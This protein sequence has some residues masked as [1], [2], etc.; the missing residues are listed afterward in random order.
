VIAGELLKGVAMTN[1]RLATAVWLCVLLSAR[2]PAAAQSGPD[3]DPDGAPGYVQ[4]VFD[5]GQIDS[6]N[7]YNGQL[8]VPIPLGPSYPIGPRLKLQLALSYNSQ[9]D[10]YGKPLAQSPDFSYRPLSGN[11]SLGIGWSLTL[12]AIKNCQHG[13]FTFGACYY[14]PDGS[15]HMFNKPRANGSIT[16]DASA[17]FLRGTGPYDM[18]DGDG[19]H[20]EFGAEG[21][22]TGYDAAAT[23]FAKGRDGWYLTR[24][25]D[26]F[27]N[28]YAV[29]YWSNINPLWTYSLP[30]QAPC[31]PGVAPLLQ[32]PATHVT[33]TS[34]IPRDIT[35]PSGQKLHINTG[36]NG[37]VGS[38]ILS[39]DFPVLVDGVLAT[40]T[41][42]FD[43]S[44]P[45]PYAKDC[46]GGT[47]LN[48]NLQELSAINLPPDL[49][50]APA[51]RFSY[52]RG[53][54]TKVTLPTSGSIAYCYAL[55]HF[56]HG[57]AGAMRP[58][59][60]PLT[61]PEAELV[62]VTEG[63]F[64]AGSAALPDVSP[65]A[66]PGECTPDNPIRWVD[67]Q[68]GVSKRTET[69]GTASN[70]TS[71]SQIA[72]PRGESGTEPQTLTIV[73]LPP[74]DKNGAGDAGRQRAKAVLF[75]SSPR[76]LGPWPAAARSSVPGDRV[77]ATVEERI[78]ES[79]PSYNLSNEPF[80]TGN[81]STD[82]GFCGSKAVRVSQST[83]EY[84]D[85]TN[86]EGDRRLQQHKTIYGGSACAS[87]DSHL[88]A[89]S[90]SSSWESNGRHYDTETH[91]GT[92]GG[93]ARTITT[94]WAPVNWPD[95]SPSGAAVL[96]GLFD[97]RTT[98][99]GVSTRDEYFEFDATDGF[100][101]GNLV[102]DGTRHV[103][104]VTCRY[105]DGA[106]NA[107]KEF[108][109]TLAASSPPAR[110]Y[111]SGTYPSFPGS[112]GT[113]GDMFGK[114]FTHLNGQLLK[115][116][117]IKGSGTPPFYFKNL[118]RDATT[119][120]ITA[121][122]DS[123]GLTTVYKYDSLG[124]VVLIDPTDDLSTF[125]CYESASATSAYRSALKQSCPVTATNP[126]LTTW[127]H[128]D[129]DGLGRLLREKRLQPA[130]AVSKRF[131][132]YDA[133][134]NAR[135]HSEWVPDSTGE[136]VSANLATA[137]AFSGGNY[138]TARPSSTPGTYRMCFDP[139][140]RPQQTV[141]AKHTSLSTV[142]R[143]DGASFYSDTRESVLTYCL[144]ATFANLQTAACSPGGLNATAITQKDALGRITS[145]TEPGSDVASYA[146]DVNGKLKA[147]TQGGQS[148][149]FAYDAAGLLRSETTPERGTVSYDSIGSLGNVRSETR[150]GGLTVTRLFDFAGRLS[151]EDAGGRKY[152]V[153]CYDGTGSCV[154]GSANFAG[155]TA[156]NGRLTRRYGYNWI[157]TI[158]PIVDEQ[159]TYSGTNGR[160]SQLATLV[161]NGDL[162]AATTQTWTYDGLGLVLQ[163][164][165]P[166]VSGTFNVTNTATNGLFTKVAANGTD[167][168]KAA[169]YA[170]AA[171]LASWT[172]GNSGAAIVTTIAQDSSMLPRPASISNALWSSGAYSYDSVGDVLAT[173]GDSFQYD[174]RARL[175]GAT[176]GGVPRTF[177]YDRYGNLTRNGTIAWTIDTATN[178]IK[179]TSFGAP[180]YDAR[181]NLVAYNGETLSYDSLDRQYRNFNGSADWVYLFDGDG[182]RIAKYPAGFTVLRREMA[183]QIA[184]ANI[185][186]RGWTL[187]TCTT[188]LFTD[189]SCAD[190]DA[191]HIHL[192]Y[193]QGVTG[194]CA[195][196]PLQ[197]CPDRTISRAEMAVFVVK[198]YKGAAY[199]PPSCTG[200]FQDVA[201]SGAYAIYAPYIE[202][203]YNDGVTAG[204][205]LSPLQFCP[206][207]TIG[208]WETSVWMSKA[209]TTPPGGAFWA[210]YHPVPRGTVYTFR[211]E[212]NRVV[213]E[214]AGGLSGAA[215]ALLSISR[216]NAYLGNLM[217][218]SYASGSWTYSA[219]DH[220]GSPRVLWNSNGQLVESHKYWPYGEDTNPTPPNQRLAYCLMERD[221]EGSHFY[222]HAR[223]HDYGLGRFLSP[224]SVGGHPAN[225]QSWNRYA[226]T[227]G[228]P[229]KY[230]DRDGNVVVGFTGLFNDPRSGVH[231][232]VATF[233]HHRFVGKTQVFRHQDIYQALGFIKSQLAIDPNQPVVVGGHSRGAAAALGL[234]RLLQKAGIKVDLLLTIDPVMIDPVATQKVPTNVKRAINYWENRS[235]PL[236]GMYLTGD[237]ST[238]DVENR[239]IGEPHGLT[240]DHVAK[241]SAELDD[242]I[243]QLEEAQ[244]EKNNKEKPN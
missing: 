99:Q 44:A 108:T 221:T 7:L 150:P 193:Q 52:L 87:C 238:T 161:G 123:A 60:P 206:G 210:A 66:P 100:L 5:H 94:D 104:F 163:H 78:F 155:G 230:L 194:G 101:K 103:A 116:G 139:F 171:G 146:Y 57:R 18:W 23:D 110:T 124:R 41:W 203:L 229:L 133:L 29:S 231:D 135:F 147:V 207:K 84:D 209:P 65:N 15:Q 31:L 89:Y 178:R 213:T 211:D 105:D 67:N 237:P 85:P 109:R 93:D 95:G 115:A 126:S 134:G 51:Y 46:G 96:P 11:P 106:G 239:Q 226:Y 240:D 35:L 30:P 152:L 59:C 164:G 8:T 21:H 28:S 220:L 185:L 80:C 179:P 236:G 241:S 215:T 244:K 121:S 187:P 177:A 129:Y 195:V 160:L 190:P 91:S 167:V 86:K 49:A 34:W 142:D 74:T 232:I 61:P 197:F 76:V 56:H 233:A 48:A 214:M 68:W 208:K 33:G 20:Y 216:D 9:V 88:V 205:N 77:G 53:L 169:S 148:R 222:D 114:D 182:E 218:A 227:L 27:G 137:C 82:E 173:G 201:C 26:P 64:C 107:D 162:S 180:Q 200:K 83:Y 199:V 149:A 25:T 47:S 140:G 16:G 219:S 3:N 98:T 10:N 70:V 151:E 198:G 90:P 243:K 224:D 55:Y 125:V 79:P 176:Y 235:S 43:Y 119:G 122:T 136:S 75:T 54:L 183:R 174:T 212:Q 156:R 102:Y 234:V 143:S 184:E 81:V 118:A 128:Y 202:Q 111:C 223:H 1:R 19:N 204:C 127:S 196:N 73:T 63:Q 42:D 175:I 72:M 158:G 144:N 13:G 159:F 36:G 188:S 131:T 38:M 189:V 130:G 6:I 186:A 217:V 97:R 58:G 141:G 165:H 228:N 4:S 14:G 132:L 157:P 117:W 138:G 153:N 39:V 2:A 154:D 145:V 37:F 242:L 50:G 120:W 166:R 225:P 45:E 22:V 69:V 112:V 192:L 181:G 32:M 40:R 168:V 17:L 71:Y 92:M 62:L 12:G 113:D 172:A 170:P 24:L 191:R